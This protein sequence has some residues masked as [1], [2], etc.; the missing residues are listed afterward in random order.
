[1]ANMNELI[2]LLKLYGILQDEAEKRIIYVT[3]RNKK[4]K[5]LYNAYPSWRDINVAMLDKMLRLSYGHLVDNCQY[6]AYNPP[7]KSDDD[8]VFVMSD[9]VTLQTAYGYIPI[10]KYASFPKKELKT[11]VNKLGYLFIRDDEV[12][13]WPLA[14]FL[15][16]FSEYDIALPLFA[17][18]IDIHKVAAALGDMQD[19]T[20]SERLTFDGSCDGTPRDGEAVKSWITRGF[21][22]PLTISELNKDFCPTLFLDDDETSGPDTERLYKE[23]HFDMLYNL[24]LRKSDIVDRVSFY[25]SKIKAYFDA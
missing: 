20:N 7:K 2:S 1:M 13:T 19:N 9:I 8:S 12:I 6:P 24:S 17:S 3:E 21:D 10:I 15:K 11:K 14:A 25:T 18:T 4:V 22:Y 5:A 16:N 23:E